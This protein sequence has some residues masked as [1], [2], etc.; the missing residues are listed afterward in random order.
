MLPYLFL[1]YIKEREEGKK[2]I[3]RKN[4]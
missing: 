1:S 2:A 4:K 3:N